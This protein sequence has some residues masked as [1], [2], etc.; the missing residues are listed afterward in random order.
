MSSHSYLCRVLRLTLL[1]SV[2]IEKIL[3]SS[4]A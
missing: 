4:G 2:I 1:A 3:A